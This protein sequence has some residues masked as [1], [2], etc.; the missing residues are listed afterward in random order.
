MIKPNNY[1][2]TNM[3]PAELTAMKEFWQTSMNTMISK[4]P[5]YNRNRTFHDYFPKDFDSVFT[6]LNENILRLDSL[7]TAEK[8]DRHKV[9]EKFRDLLNYTQLGYIHTLTTMGVRFK[10]VT[11]N[12]PKVVTEKQPKTKTFID[13]GQSN[14]DV[15]SVGTM[16]DNGDIEVSV[17]GK[18]TPETLKA[19]LTTEDYFGDQETKPECDSS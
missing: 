16:K 15:F 2:D 6:Y 12:V 4:D 10:T 11:L 3:T 19:K 8:P 18:S 9:E 17:V 7:M 1:G 14:D 13:P 5:E